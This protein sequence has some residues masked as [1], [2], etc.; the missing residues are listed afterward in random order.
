M[1]LLD[2]QD[3]VLNGERSTICNAISGVSQGSVLGP[4]LFLIYINDSVLSTALNGNLY[5]DDIVLY[6][7]INS[8]QD[9]KYVQQGIDSVGRWVDGNDFHLNSAK[10][11]FMVIHYEEN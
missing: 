1:F 11:K 8:L 10:C 2:V 5:T 3:I 4:L 7:V 9:I 6:R